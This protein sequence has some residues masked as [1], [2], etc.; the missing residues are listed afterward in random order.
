MH[1][2]VLLNTRSAGIS[3]GLSYETGALQV[4]PGQLVEA[5]LRGKVTEGL[6]I[7]VGEDPDNPPSYE[8]KA[9]KTLISEEPLLTEAHVETMRWMAVYYRCSL[10]AAA[11]VFLPSPSWKALLPDTQVRYRL[12]TVGEGR[13]GAKQQLLI[14]ALGSKEWITEDTLKK[15]VLVS[16]AALRSLIEKGWI[17]REEVQEKMADVRSQI[18]VD[19]GSTLNQAQNDALTTIRETNKPTLLFGVTA[20]GKTE[21]YAQLIAD[22][23][24]AGR[25]AILLVPEILLTEHTIGRFQTMFHTDRIAIVHSKLGIAA[26]KSLWKKIHCGAID[27]VVG[28][29][30]ALF[31]PCPNLGLV[32]LDEEHEWTYKNEQTPRYHARETAEALCK[33]AHAKL[34]FGSATPSVESWY[35]AT[36]GQYVLARMPERYSGQLMPTVRVIDLADV[37]FGKLYPFSP[38]LIDAIR[39]R[40]EKKEQTVMFLNR[41]GAASS[42][43]CLKC[44]RRLTSPVSELPFT[45]H[46]DPSGKPF[47]VDHIGGARADMPA[48]C[49]SCGATE[50]LPVG[51][52]TQKLEDLLKQLF[53]TA[54]VLRADSDTLKTPEEMRD[55]LAAMREEKA[56]ILLGTQTVVKG[57]DLPKVTLAAV[58]VADVGLSLPHFRAGER[59]FQLLTQL[60][61]RSG[62]AAPGEVIIQTF[63]PNA[64]EIMAAA[65]HR[66]EDWLNA[67]MGMRSQLHYPP[68]TQIVRFIVRGPSAEARARSLHRSVDQTIKEKSLSGRATVAQTFHDFRVWHIL[69]N[70]ADA[71]TLLDSIG[72]VDAVIDVDP[73]DVL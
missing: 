13:I 51:A 17:E 44:R 71:R 65:T 50:L 49:P 58:P 67:E 15:N 37:T 2:L 60:T 3:G 38:P 4:R 70:G 12:V 33:H 57:L 41:R 20:S 27:L 19:I 72:N 7:A 28:S 61:G 29:R 56:D 31:S 47:L 36:N 35:R 8:L 34:I 62:R 26:R 1:C 40:L 48:R 55:V 9:I 46:H 30:S 6:V 52:G 68:S 59:I 21:I 22:T 64:P 23:V 73:L 53:P 54:R 16:G 14:D 42:V 24:N 25:Q 5:T 43:L 69:Y 66:T 10:R 45:L 39:D 63:R 32:I 11:S 18:S